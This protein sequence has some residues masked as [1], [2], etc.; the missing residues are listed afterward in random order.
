VA[1]SV[2]PSKH[3]AERRRGAGPPE[4]LSP[5]DEARLGDFA[6]AGGT[7]GV[8]GGSF[9]GGRASGVVYVK[10]NVRCAWRC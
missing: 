4:W 9:G 2:G 5:Y 3:F 10:V 6:T 1:T 7:S 8:W